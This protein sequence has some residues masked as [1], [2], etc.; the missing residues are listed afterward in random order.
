[1]ALTVIS[2]TAASGTPS[3]RL[4]IEDSVNAFTASLPVAL[5][6]VQG[7]IGN[8]APVSFS[9]RRYQLPGLRAGAANAVLRLNVTELL[10]TTPSLTFLLQLIY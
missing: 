6:N 8:T 9:W 1:L 2:L 4:Q 3:A 5:E 10:G 7:P